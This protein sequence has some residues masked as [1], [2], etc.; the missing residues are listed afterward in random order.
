[1]GGAAPPVDAEER[2]M[3]KGLLLT[4]ALLLQRAA[5]RGCAGDG[6]CT[7]AVRASAAGPDAPPAIG[8][9]RAGRRRIGG[10][11]RGLPARRPT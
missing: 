10:L 7:G 5:S 3:P 2:E 8:P 6:R 9:A 1:V 11:V 4:L